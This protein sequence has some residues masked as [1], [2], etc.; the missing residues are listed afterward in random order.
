[1][2]I[3]L[4]IAGLCIWAISIAIAIEYQNYVGFTILMIVGIYMSRVARVISRLEES[5]EELNLKIIKA[6]L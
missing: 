2:R 1:M 6:A 3:I 5:Q 4:H